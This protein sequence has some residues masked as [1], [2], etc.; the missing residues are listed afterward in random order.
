MIKAGKKDK[1]RVVEILVRS[2]EVDPHTNW[3]VKADESGKAVRLR[4]LMDV[5][6]EEALI[7]DLVYLTDDRTGVALWKRRGT[8]GFSF[9]R[10][11]SQLRFALAFGWR[12]TRDILAMERY[13]Q[14]H[15]PP[16]DF[17]YLWFIGVLPEGQGKGNASELLDPVLKDCEEEKLPVYLQTANPRNVRIYERKG[18]QI[19]HHWEPDDDSGLRVWFMRRDK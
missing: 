15:H 14:K 16:E 19:Y 8:A 17:L 18:F 7:K 1:T 11:L 10:A 5:A 3:L 12:R 4:A 6:F 2:F 13:V 9:A